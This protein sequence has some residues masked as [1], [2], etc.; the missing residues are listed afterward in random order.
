MFISK[1]FAE[2]VWTNHERKSAQ[3]KAFVSNQEYIL[4]ARFDETEIPG[5]LQTIGY[6]NAVEYSPKELAEFIKQKIGPLSKKEFF[7]DD[8]DILYKQAGAKTK[9]SKRQVFILGKHFFEQLKSMTKEERE[10]LFETLANSCPS[11]FPENIHLNIELLRRKSKK[12]IDEIISMYSRLDCIGIKASI[13]N[14]DNEK[15]NICKGYRIIKIIYYNL[16]SEVREPRNAT[17]IPIAIIEVMREAFCPECARRA[18]VEL[19]FSI[20]SSLTGF[21][22]KARGK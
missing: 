12:T 5:L 11:D 6:I 1:H 13:E 2:K 17:F 9:K 4:P 7:P 19:D 15:D 20:L 18:F 10:L 8:P 16:L 14:H 21:P 22:E 3:A